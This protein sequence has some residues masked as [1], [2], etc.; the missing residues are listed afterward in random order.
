MSVEG[1]DDL[2]FWDRH[3]DFDNQDNHD[4]DRE[5]DL[6]DETVPQRRRVSSLLE[7]PEMATRNIHHR[8]NSS[9]KTTT[10]KKML[11]EDAVG[12]RKVI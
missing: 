11:E 9:Y 5:N 4:R 8:V 12:M 6:P 7:P 1:D 2:D 10:V 3:N